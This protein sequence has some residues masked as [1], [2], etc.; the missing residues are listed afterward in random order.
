MIRGVRAIFWAVIDSVRERTL[1]RTSASDLGLLAAPRERD[2]SCSQRLTSSV[3]PGWKR[4]SLDDALEA[5]MTDRR[6][7]TSA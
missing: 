6:R 1:D 5:A 4:M 3:R 7:Q 2:R